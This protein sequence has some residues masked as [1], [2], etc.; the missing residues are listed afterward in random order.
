MPFQFPSSSPYLFERNERVGCGSFYCGHTFIEILLRFM[1]IGIA[2]SRT[3]GAH[4]GSYVATE[5]LSG[6]VSHGNVFV[7]LQF[8][9]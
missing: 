5:L 1:G 3:V 6:F 2:L 7:G 9:E 8:N 4:Y